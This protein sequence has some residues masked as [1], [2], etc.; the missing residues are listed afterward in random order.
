MFGFGAGGFGAAQGQ[1]PACE[2]VDATTLRLSGPTDRVM[3]NCVRRRLSAEITDIIITSRGG[4]T[5]YGREIGALIGAAPRTLTIEDACLSSCGN[6][7]VPA[8]ARLKLADGAYIA[9]HG[10]LDPLTLARSIDPTPEMLEFVEAELA[11]EAAYARKFGVARGWRIYRDIGD[12][13]NLITKDME[14][15]ARDLGSRSFRGFLVVERPFLESCLPHIEIVA[16]AIER[17]VIFDLER[18]KDLRRLGGWGTG[19]V[20]CKPETGQKADA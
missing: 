20:T 9:L 4:P 12:S 17:S 6:Y 15:E 7:I 14:G 18:R 11:A 2:L 10:T 19:S 8:A 13:S 3:R 16:E 5:D 1:R